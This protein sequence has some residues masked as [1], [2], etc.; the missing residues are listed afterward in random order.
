MVEILPAENPGNL[1]DYRTT[2]RGFDWSSFDSEFD[3]SREGPYNIVA[4][5]VD[6]HGHGERRDK[7]ALYS[8][9]ADY[10]LRS[11]TFGEMS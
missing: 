5:A 3:W 2:Y 4:E 7:V 10:D 11:H 8:V 9:N 6:R 1:R